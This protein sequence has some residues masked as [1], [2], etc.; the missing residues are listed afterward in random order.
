MSRY[1]PT[2]SELCGPHAIQSLRPC[3]FLSDRL[4]E[5]RRTDSPCRGISNSTSCTPLKRGNVNVSASSMVVFGKCLLLVDLFV[6]W[7]GTAV[8]YGL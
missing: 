6:C 5:K 7:Y 4:S 3:I 2:H 8:F 1:A